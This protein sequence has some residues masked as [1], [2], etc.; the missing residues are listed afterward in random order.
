M[1][2]GFKRGF[3][4]EVCT[5]MALVLGVYGASLFGESIGGWLTEAIN[6]DERMAR[7]LAFAL[8]FTA[9]VVVVFLFGKMLEGAVKMVAMGPLNKTMGIVIGG[10]KHAIIL[11]ALIFLVNG[12]AGRDRWLPHTWA[13]NSYLYPPLVEL[14]PA[15]YP[16]LRENK[17]QDELKQKWQETRDKVTSLP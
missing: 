5:L 11:S 2:L 7:L 16:K 15:L 10:L 12:F 1:Y 14:A 4:I 8:V 6:T 13:Q 9:I 17:W 3:I